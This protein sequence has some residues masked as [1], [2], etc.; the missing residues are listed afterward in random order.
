MIF[1]IINRIRGHKHIWQVRGI[2]RY[3]GATYKICLKCRETFV[4]V[5]KLSE[6][7][8]WEKCD[9]IID[10]DSQFDDNDKFIFT[11][12]YENNS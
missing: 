9:P 12:N 8:R 5:N 11:K 6:E 4:R 3:G 2:N 7:E 10:L 1:T